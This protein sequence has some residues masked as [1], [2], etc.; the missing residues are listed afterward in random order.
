MT[1]KKANPK[2]AK[3]TSAGGPMPAD[4]VDPRALA[5]GV[6]TAGGYAVPKQLAGAKRKPRKKKGS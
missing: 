4:P 3:Q 2:T 5:L 1:R 6:D